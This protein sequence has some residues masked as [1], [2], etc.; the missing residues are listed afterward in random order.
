MNRN[1]DLIFKMNH[2]RIEMNSY[3]YNQVEDARIRENLLEQLSWLNHQFHFYSDNNEID[4][5]I[6]KF[7]WVVDN[8]NESLSLKEEEKF[9]FFDLAS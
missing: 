6:D 5:L 2:L 9:P 8:F 7:N 4:L 1:K 3:L